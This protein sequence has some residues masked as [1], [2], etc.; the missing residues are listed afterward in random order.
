MIVFFI[1]N[2]ATALQKWEE[3]IFGPL[4]AT[5]CLLKLQ[6]IQE[7]NVKIVYAHKY[8]CPC[9]SVWVLTASDLAQSKLDQK[10][11][12]MLIYTWRYSN[13]LGEQALN[14]D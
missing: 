7:K 6:Y 10:I 4:Y 9:S 1:I 14:S 2:F 3:R 13:S 5:S 12:Y 11:K 8:H